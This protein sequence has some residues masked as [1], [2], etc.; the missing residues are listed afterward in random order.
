MGGRGDLI[1]GTISIRRTLWRNETYSPKT[2]ASEATIRIPARA[3]DAL[4]RHTR[5]KGNPRVGRLFPTRNGNPVAAPNFHKSWK[6][7]LRR[8]GLPESLTF[9]QLRH[10][11]ASLLLSQGVPVSIVSKYLRHSNPGV[12]L[13]IYAHVLDETGGLAADAM[14]Q[15]PGT[16]EGPQQRRLRAL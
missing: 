5:A 3:L 12:T 6:A 13:T 1:E 9:H 10:G 2:G 16:G 11:A 8:A 14:D 4:R 15:A 7:M